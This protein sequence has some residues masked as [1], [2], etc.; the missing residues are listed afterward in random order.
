VE[1]KLRQLRLRREMG[2]LNWSK[3]SGLSPVLLPKLKRGKLYPTLPTLSRIALLFSVGLD[4]FF[5][6]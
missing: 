5:F 6:R 2:L 4:H 3:H 1:D